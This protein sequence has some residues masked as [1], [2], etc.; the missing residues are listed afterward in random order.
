MEVKSAYSHLSTPFRHPPTGTVQSSNVREVRDGQEQSTLLAVQCGVVVVVSRES[1]P[2]RERRRR[3]SL[4]LEHVQL[5]R[6]PEETHLSVC[7]FRSSMTLRIPT[8]SRFG[9]R[10]D[11]GVSALSHRRVECSGRVRAL[12]ARH[13]RCLGLFNMGHVICSSW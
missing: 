2:G 6:R 13:G 4:L 9:N 10:R 5:S 1:Y 11:G 3:R 7:D 12:I 8:R